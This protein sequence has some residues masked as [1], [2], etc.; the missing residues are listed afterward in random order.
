MT[1]HRPLGTL[2]WTLILLVPSAPAAARC[3]DQLVDTVRNAHVLVSALP[4]DTR[5]DER[6]MTDVRWMREQLQL[7]DAACLRGG[8]VEAAWRVEAVLERLKR[9]PVRERLSGG[10]H[11]GSAMGAGA[12]MTI[13]RRGSR[14]V[15]AEPIAS[16]LTTSMVPP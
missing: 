11:E 6:S 7:I 12:A 9:V 3:N 5:G 4:D 14:T 2:W 13:G 10:L 15:K 8:D 16:R 1:H